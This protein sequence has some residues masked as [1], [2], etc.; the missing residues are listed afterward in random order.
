VRK[1]VTTELKA[2]GRMFSSGDLRG[3]LKK[4]RAMK[5][6]ECKSVIAD[7]QFVKLE[8]PKCKV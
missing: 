5:A 4:E 2:V 7:Y 6:N 8:T 3:L 1:R